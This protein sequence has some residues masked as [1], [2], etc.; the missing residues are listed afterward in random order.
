MASFCIKILIVERLLF[1][2]LLEVFVKVIVYLRISLLCLE[3]PCHL[4]HD[5]LNSDNLE[6]YSFFVL[7][8]E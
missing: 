7:I 6:T 2:M 5:E 1:F 8:K 3:R 4:I